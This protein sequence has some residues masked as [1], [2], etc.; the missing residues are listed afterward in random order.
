MEK[1]RT[2]QVPPRDGQRGE[3][4]AA[5]DDHSD[6]RRAKGGIEMSK[7]AGKGRREFLK[8]AAVGSAALAGA[9]SGLFGKFDVAGGEFA[10]ARVE[11]EN[12]RLR[13]AFI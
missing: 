6:N 9:A 4:I 13:M 5:I 7:A 12:N 3:L 11:A 2:R 8:T 1:K 10:V